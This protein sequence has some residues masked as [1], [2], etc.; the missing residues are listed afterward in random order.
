MKSKT[1]AG[2]MGPPGSR[3][4]TLPR[5]L[6]ASEL[7]GALEML[8]EAG[9]PT[10]DLGHGSLTRIFAL[11]STEAPLG[12]VGLEVYGNFGLL[13]SLVVTP[14]LRGTGLGR[15]LVEF[16]EKKAREE[17]VKE[18]YLLTLSAQSF[19]Q[20]LGYQKLDRSLAPEPIRATR[21]YS[22]ICPFRAIFMGKR[23]GG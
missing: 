15:S 8:R 2:H 6:H 14:A 7:G 4:E 1:M 21:E 11:E 18:L 3:L 10:E 17:G 22:E 5:Q 23:L 16:A 13:R 20:R 19:F 12:L 9:L